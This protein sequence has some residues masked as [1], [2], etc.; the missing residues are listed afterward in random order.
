MTDRFTL[1]Q[2]GLMGWALGDMLDG[3]VAVATMAACVAVVLLW[4]SAQEGAK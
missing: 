4:P 1:I 2:G 3:W